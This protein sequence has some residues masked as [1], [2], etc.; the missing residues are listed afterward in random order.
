MKPRP[1]DRTFVGQPRPRDRD[2]IGL[3]SL[4]LAHEGVDDGWWEAE[5]I[6]ING[7]VFSLRWYDYPTEPTILSK[8]GE[9]ALPPPRRGLSR[10]AS[11]RSGFDVARA[12]KRPR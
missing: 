2:E 7:S 4:V 10:P 6:G 12:A 8:A 3:G 9:L 11:A 1:G 5:V